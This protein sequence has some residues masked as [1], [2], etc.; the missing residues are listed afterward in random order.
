MGELMFRAAYDG[1]QAVHLTV[2]RLKPKFFPSCYIGNSKLHARHHIET[3]RATSSPHLRR[4][5]AELDHLSAQCPCPFP[6]TGLLPESAHS[7]DA[8]A[9]SV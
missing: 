6:L 1:T 3:R 5:H 7:A 4:L 9:L 8:A 2:S